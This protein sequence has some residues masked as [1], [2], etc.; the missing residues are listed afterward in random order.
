MTSPS[1][2]SIDEV[3]RVP[4]R[5]RQFHRGGDHLVV[6][7]HNDERDERRVDVGGGEVDRDHRNTQQARK[8]QWL[9]DSIDDGRKLSVLRSTEQGGEYALTQRIGAKPGVL[10]LDG[11]DGGRWT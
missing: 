1:E 4:F 7:A 5:G 6:A 9:P 11:V 10:R 2:A 8:S 3:S